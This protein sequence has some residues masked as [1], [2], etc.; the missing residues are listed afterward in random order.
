MVN[1]LEWDLQGEGGMVQVPSPSFLNFN[2]SST[3][4]E[5][6]FFLSIKG[7]FKWMVR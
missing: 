7:L 6:G 5:V 4:Q 3:I 2:S 1:Q